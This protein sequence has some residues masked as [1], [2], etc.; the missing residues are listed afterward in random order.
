MESDKEEEEKQESRRRQYEVMT[1]RIKRWKR[2]LDESGV[3]EKGE[4]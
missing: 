1:E 4:S 3:H 2:F